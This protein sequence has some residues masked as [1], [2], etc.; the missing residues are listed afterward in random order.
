MK[1]ESYLVGSLIFLAW[2]LLVIASVN[3][4]GAENVE[5]FP[6]EGK[7][8]ARATGVVIKVDEEFWGLKISD[9]RLFILTGDY[10]ENL[11]RLEG[12]EVT[13]EGL[14]RPRKEID[15]KLIPVIEVK[16]QL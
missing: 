16:F 10:V 12:K 6:R 4:L 3:A 13:V 14:L 9:T 15:K 11:K 8:W 1:L 2:I 7:L 5:F